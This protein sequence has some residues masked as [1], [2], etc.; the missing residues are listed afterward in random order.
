MDHTLLERA[1]EYVERGFSVIPLKSRSKKPVLPS[2][3]EYQHRRPTDDQLIHW[4]G[5]GCNYNIGIVTGQISNLMVIDLDSGNAVELARS[6]GLPPSPMVK[7]GRGYHAYCS[8]IEGVR[9]FQ[10][11]ADLPEIDLR[12]E[13]GYVVAPPSI[14]ETGTP[15]EWVNGCSLDD[16]PLPPIP[17]WLTASTP[18]DKQPLSALYKCVE[19]GERNNALV[20]LV[21]SWVYDG[22]SLKDIIEQALVWNSALTQPLPEDEVHRTVTSIF[23]KHYKSEAWPEP[24]PLPDGL[25]P[26]QPFNFALLPNTLRPWAQDICERIQCPPDF[27][28]VTIM[29]GLGAIIGRKIGIRPQAHTDWTESPNQWALVIGRPGVLKSP[30]IEAALSPLKRLVAQATEAHKLEVEDYKRAAKLANI[31]TDVG[32]KAAKKT[33]AKSPDADVSS[34]LNIK[35]PEAPIMRRYIT[36]DSTAAALGELHRQNPNG[37][38]VHRDEMVSLL[39][40]LDREDNS[41]A[42]GFYLTG[43]NG[44]SAYTFDRISRGMNLH[45]S[46]VCLSMLGS[47]QPGR[48]AEYIGQAVRGGTG[49]DGL[50]QRFGLLVWPD[51]RGDWQNCDRWP[52]DDA[53]R[54][55]DRIYD[56]LDTLNPA[57]IGAQQDIDSNGQLE[58]MPYLRF[59]LEALELFLKWRAILER[60]LRSGELHLALESHLAKYRKLVPGLALILHL[61]DGNTGPV[62]YRSTLQA[63][64]WAKYLETHARRAYASIIN[65]EVAAAKAI[66][67]RIRKGDLSRTFSSRD[68]W[69]PGWAMLSD[70]EQVAAALY[71]LVDLDWLRVTQRE[72]GGRRATVYEV[73][74]RGLS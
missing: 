59:S 8:Y 41:E 61:A 50:I 12:A 42:R 56:S 54:A 71:L 67:E 63:I 25:L 70:R 62:G 18:E 22:G 26:I 4:F 74:P 69:R 66:I 35:E 64:A 52:D 53:K 39:K 19:K 34:L 72:T 48:I 36:N 10:K 3:K 5:N 29:A 24:Q 27:V 47:T 14:H 46:A 65:P 28:A 21:G 44:N 68:V 31:M 37:L 49:D 45:I 11:R 57:V 33:L 38:L 16:Y 60:R 58:G 9:N 51:T 1:R 13:G 2:W 6:L 43:W 73:N 15:Y 32:E 40:Y 20:R 7:T 23:D 30:A 55:A 17:A